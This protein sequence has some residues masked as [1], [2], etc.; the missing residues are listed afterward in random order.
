[1]SISGACEGGG[2]ARFLCE[3]ELTGTRRAGPEIFF[4]DFLT[5]EAT[6]GSTEPARDEEELFARVPAFLI[7]GVDEERGDG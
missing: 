4:V 7:A 3:G 2:E 6:S 1:M 5:G